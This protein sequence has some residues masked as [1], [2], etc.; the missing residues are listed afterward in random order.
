MTRWHF[1]VAVLAL[2]LGTG[3]VAQHGADQRDMALVGYSDLQAR[4]VYQPT[5]HRQ[6]DRYIAYI[7][8]HGGRMP[9]PLTGQVRTK[10]HVR[11]RRHE[12]EEPPLSHAHPRRDGRG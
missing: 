10:W 3:A 2:G 11:S 5:I 8:H 12:S 6:G 7:G 1:G 4:S 9:N